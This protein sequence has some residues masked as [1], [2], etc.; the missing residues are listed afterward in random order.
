MLDYKKI[1][2][3]LQNIEN[4]YV[5]I[6]KFFNLLD[7][8]DDKIAMIIIRY[9]IKH[10]FDIFISYPFYTLCLYIPKNRYPE[11]IN[12]I[13]S[14]Y[15]I[16]KEKYSLLE[17]LKK[18]HIIYKNKFF[19]NKDIIEQIKYLINLKHLIMALFD[20]S[21]GGAPF[22]LKIL[23][24]LKSNINNC[25]MMTI[26]SAIERLRKL[27]NLMGSNFFTILK[28]KIVT[29]ETFLTFSDEQVV[30]YIHNVYIKT[31]A[32]LS[33]TIDLFEK[34]N[35]INLKMDNL[36]NPSFVNIEEESV[37]EDDVEDISTF[38]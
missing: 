19:W 6:F 35:M 4:K 37:L 34:Y 25:R 36:L 26:N 21:N 23:P 22:A 29:V 2:S 17:Q 33:G 9:I 30:Q 8:F 14:F 10:C 38:F 15:E 24:I 1:D 5:L 13:L 31:I 20:N 3:D 32:I 18:W 12:I 7:F 27:F 28:I 16:S 11:T